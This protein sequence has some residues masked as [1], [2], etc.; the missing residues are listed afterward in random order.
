M[1]EIEK[2]V[3]VEEKKE[4]VCPEQPVKTVENEPVENPECNNNEDAS[5][6]ADKKKKKKK[7]KKKP[8]TGMMLFLFF[9]FF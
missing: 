5:K 1:A 6:E 4:E 9:I 7:S 2:E 8:V 3:N